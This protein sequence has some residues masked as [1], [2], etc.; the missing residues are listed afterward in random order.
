M[1]LTD[2]IYAYPWTNPS[3]NNTNSYLIRSRA[4]VLVD[5]GH[6]Q[7]L[8]HLFQ[9]LRLDGIHEEGI[10]GVIGTHAHPD[11]VEGLAAFTHRPVWTA[12]GLKDEA[13]LREAGGDFYRMMG[14]SPPELRIDVL[15]KEGDLILKG[16]RFQVLETPGHSPGSVCLYW[17][18]R[19]ALFVGDVVFEMG[20][21]RTD[22]PGGDGKAL[23]ES[24]ERLSRLDVELLLPGHGNPLVGRE[25]IQRNYQVIRD[26]YYAYL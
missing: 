18:D 15:L 22:F 12:L 19:K 6:A 3:A 16:E 17:P 10:E 9:S 21:G 26:M 14:M 5:P 8:S 2:G 1:K 11:H 20:V 4:V 13:F 24:L 7:F 23:K 25:R